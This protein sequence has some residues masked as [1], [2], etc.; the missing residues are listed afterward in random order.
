MAEVDDDRPR[1]PMIVY[2]VIGGLAILGL[3][4]IWGF[5]MSTIFTVVRL[6]LWGIVALAVFMVLKAILWGRRDK[7]ARNDT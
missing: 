1:L 2:L 7:P 5:V 4:S 3:I 6:V